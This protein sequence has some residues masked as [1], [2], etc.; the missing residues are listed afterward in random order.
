MALLYTFNPW[1]NPADVTRKPPLVDI[2]PLV[3]VAA[4]VA[5]EDGV[6]KVPA[7]LPHPSEA[8]DTLRPQNGPATISRTGM[9][10]IL[11]QEGTLKRKALASDALRPI[12][13][14]RKFTE[15]FLS[16]HFFD[17]VAPYLSV[18]VTYLVSAQYI[19]LV[20]WN[21]SYRSFVRGSSCSSFVFATRCKHR[22][23]GCTRRKNVRCP[24]QNAVRTSVHSFSESLS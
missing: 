8:D 10:R 5:A 9:M 6:V 16:A 3:E 2:N 23:D 22:L 4:A 1:S 7:G 14:D 19:H 12:L 11:R 20:A 21:R 15:V 13:T 24:W 18:N 17:D